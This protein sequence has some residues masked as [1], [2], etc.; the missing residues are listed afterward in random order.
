MSN[1]STALALLALVL[2]A[3]C[4]LSA[5]WMQFTVERAAD[6]AAA[7]A[8]PADGDQTAITVCAGLVNYR[9]C[10]VSQASAQPRPAAA[11][12]GPNPWPVILVITPVL[13]LAV[14]VVMAGLVRLDGAR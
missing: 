7:A 9:S 6:S 2:L 14:S 13:L 11:D 8:M 4:A 12:P 5:A 3:G 1:K 10:T